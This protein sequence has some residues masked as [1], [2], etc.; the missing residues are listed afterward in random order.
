[1]QS[2]S[3]SAHFGSDFYFQLSSFL[4]SWTR[5]VH[6][7]S[8]TTIRVVYPARVLQGD[9]HR[10]TRPPPSRILRMKSLCHS[11]SSLFLT[12]IGVLAIPARPVDLLAC[13]FGCCFLFSDSPFARK[14]AMITSSIES[15]GAIERSL[16]AHDGQPISV[17]VQPVDPAQVHIIV[18]SS[19]VELASETFVS[20]ASITSCRPDWF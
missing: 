13:R 11:Q 19:R 9:V 17:H 20:Q 18:G 10:C 12:E 15:S 16:R 5:D 2:A 6:I 8:G 14:D 7:V 4:C 1:M 3:V